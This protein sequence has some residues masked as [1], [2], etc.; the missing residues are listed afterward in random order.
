MTAMPHPLVHLTGGVRLHRDALLSGY[1][2]F[3]LHQFRVHVRRI[4]SCMKVL[5]GCGDRGLRAAWREM[6]VATNPARDWDVFD[7]AIVLHLPDA[8]G[9]ALR[10]ALESPRAAARAHALE[11]LQ[12]ADWNSLER[13]WSGWLAD[14][15]D[16]PAQA[17]PEA[18]PDLKREVGLARA[19]AREEDDRSSWHRLRIAIKNL[20]YVA[21]I[22]QLCA[23]PPSAAP[24]DVDPLVEDCKRLQDLLGEWHDCMVQLELL[25][26]PAF[27]AAPV[28]ARERLAVILAA[29][30][31]QLLG[32]ARLALEHWGQGKGTE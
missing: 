10:A 27:R 7:T 14:L 22:P 4:R 21:D 28:A 3:D 24:L 6:F 19:R 18:L 26:G 2:P 25:Q 1:A 13:S 5:P 16:I 17:A 9:E 12:S 8:N 31:D 29:R 20:R 30:R 11:R 23:A 15:G 32:E